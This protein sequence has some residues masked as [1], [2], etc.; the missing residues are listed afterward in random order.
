MKSAAL[1]ALVL[2]AVACGAPA[3]SAS[4]VPDLPIGDQLPDDFKADGSWG[5]ALTCKTIPSLPALVAPQ[6]T[7]SIDGLTLHVV[8]P[9]S[10]FDK[11]FPVG[12]GVIEA[13]QLASAYRESKTYYPIVAT[14][15]ASFTLRLA[16]VQ[17]CKTWWTD[18]DTGK[19]QPV[20]AGLPFMPFYGGFAMHGPIDNFRASD[21]GTLRRG[22]VSHGC[23][24]M[25]AAD[26]LELYARLRGVASGKVPVHLQRE[27]ERDAQGRRVD[28]SA[29][30]VGAECVSDGECNF[31][32][33]FC[34]AN[35]YATR[36]FCSARCTTTC[37]DRAGYPTT[38]CV[39]DPD[40][41]ALGLCVSKVLPQN[42]DCRPGDHLVP[43]SLPRF[44][45]TVQAT[46]CVPGSPGWVGDHCFRD[47]ECEGGTHCAGATVA[48]PGL[49]TVS[50]ARFCADQPGWPTTFCAA[51]PSLGDGCL[52]AC[53]PA[54]NASECAADET[55]SER[56]R[57]GEPGTRRFVCVP[58]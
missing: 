17:P 35:R 25:E 20:F 3:P 47:T 4:T 8:D 44:H 41:P 6:I 50:C 18:P 43:A 56:A 48:R 57:V 28:L 15:G 40:Q 11:I 42:Q 39:A 36:G 10:G 5:A 37:A 55:C 54:S 31:A 21:G 12:V 7:I 49:C 9:Q 22:F 58:G 30:W 46:V 27:P 38:F 26:V 16:D 1:L 33:G 13:D 53:T 51:D 29:K 24:R 32:G 34:K 19:Q 14:G 52:R 23:V 2:A 45:Q